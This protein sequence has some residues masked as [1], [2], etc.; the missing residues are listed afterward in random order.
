MLLSR[1]RLVAQG[2]GRTG[3][4]R[5]APGRARDARRVPRGGR[6][7][8]PCRLG[9]GSH[10]GTSHRGERRGCGCRFNGAKA[11]SSTGTALSGRLGWHG[12]QGR[13]R[14]RKASRIQSVV[15]EFRP[16][17][18]IP[19][20]AVLLAIAVDIGSK[21]VNFLS[22]HARGDPLATHRRHPSPVTQLVDQGELLVTPTIPG[23]RAG[24]VEPCARIEDFCSR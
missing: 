16:C 3:L 20:G 2:P 17:Q 19:R 22:A 9:V 8:G 1:R 13:R 12:R 7:W 18:A 14:A 23:G 6:T 11:A 5:E 10:R 4:G 24:R 21:A 15:V